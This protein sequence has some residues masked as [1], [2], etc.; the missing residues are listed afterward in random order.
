LT[1]QQNDADAA[2]EGAH[3]GKPGRLYLRE[4]VPGELA[5]VGQRD[6]LHHCERP[7]GKEHQADFNHTT[8][9]AVIV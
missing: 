8:T 4:S 9:S 6:F 7:F 3:A 2:K 1:S 5:A